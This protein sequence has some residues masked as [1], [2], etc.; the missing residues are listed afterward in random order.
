MK[1]QRILI[2]T[3]LSVKSEAAIKTAQNFINSP[4]KKVDLL[5]VIPLSRYLGDSFDRL[6]IPLSMEKD[7]FPKII[8]NKKAELT[9]FADKLITNAANRGEI[10]ITIDRKAS[11]SIL[12][13]THKTEY[14]L[15]LM[16]AKGG[17]EAAFFH[18]SATD[19]IIRHS[20]IPVFTLTEKADFS[21]VN[22][23]VVPC[24][25]SA[26]SL[27]ALPVAFAVAAQ[28]DADIELLNVLELY[29]ADIYGLEPTLQIEQNEGNL[30]KNL[31]NKMREYFAT[32]T[33][34]EFSLLENE[35]GKSG[36][37]IREQDGEK[38][39]LNVRCVIR[40]SVAAHHEIIEYANT[41]AD[42]L[43]M[44]THGHTGLARMLLGS[45][46]EQVIQ[47]LEKPQITV[48]SELNS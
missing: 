36:Q 40:K 9:E 30:T 41:N 17:H 43:V 19:K 42:L 14:D 47:H 12:K 29:S 34:S 38:K 15:I 45:T 11:D 10:H 13:Q 46:T 27:A 6:G 8:E 7:V 33:Q 44:S 39:S 20:S 35:D 28:F 48:K 18:G 2:P 5:H 31:F 16:S 32:Y 23:V 1:I 4:G 26:R 24:D 37:I 3:D 21:Q 25:F 22:T